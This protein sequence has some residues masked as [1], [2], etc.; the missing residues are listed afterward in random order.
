MYRSDRDFRSVSSDFGRE[1]SGRRDRGDQG[2]A[3]PHFETTWGYELL[4][5]SRAKLIL[6]LFFNIFKDSSVGL[7]DPRVNISDTSHCAFALG[8]AGS[9]RHAGA[10]DVI[11]MFAHDDDAPPAIPAATMVI[12]R[13]SPQGRAPEVLMVQRAK[14]MRFA[15]GAAVFPGG[16]VDEADR[17]LA[18]IG[19]AH[20]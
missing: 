5:M 14:E 8:K 1:S 4:R 17:V 9:A 11:E 2:A 7:N 6:W 10:M 13:N 20:V 12:F 3:P 19:R 15:G 16:R 18:E